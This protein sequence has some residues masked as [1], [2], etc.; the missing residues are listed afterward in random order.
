MANYNVVV[1]PSAGLN[2]TR[3]KYEQICALIDT[4]IGLCDENHGFSVDFY[5]KVNETEI[6]EIYI[7]AEEYGE[8]HNIPNPAL[9]VI[10]ELIAENSLPYLQFGAAFTCSKMRAGSHGGCYFRIYPDGSIV[11]PVVTWAEDAG[12]QQ[13]DPVIDGAPQQ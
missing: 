10:G 5:P 7:M 4:E 11:E 6:G 3:A 8:W 2:C 9:R 1:T 12:F 13:P